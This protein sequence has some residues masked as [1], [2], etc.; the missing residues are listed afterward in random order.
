MH[1][2]EVGWFEL[3]YC[4][5]PW[6]TGFFRP[7]TADRRRQRYNLSRESRVDDTPEETMFSCRAPI[8]HLDFKHYMRGEL[9][10]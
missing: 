7:I 1:A 6:F 9:T 4:C 3:D 8:F 5:L 10:P 2:L